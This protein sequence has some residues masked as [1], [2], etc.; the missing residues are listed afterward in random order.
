MS[1][2]IRLL[3]RQLE[4]EQ[5][6][7]ET[8][9]AAAA[10]QDIRLPL[11][12]RNGVCQLCSAQLLTGRVNA[13]GTVG[14]IDSDQHNSAEIMLCRAEALTDCEFEIANV[15]GPGEL[16]LNNVICQVERVESILAHVYRVELRLPAGKKPEFYAGQYLALHLPDKEA[17]SF[18]SIASAPGGECLE[19]H[20]Q[21]DP[22][23]ATASEIITYLQSSPSVKV[24]LPHGRACLAKA[25]EQNV[26]LLAAG[27]GFAQMKSI[28]EYLLCADYEGDI[29]LYW[30]VRQ[31][32]DMYL[33]EYTERWAANNPRFHFTSVI[34]DIE[35]I[36]GLEHHDQLAD[37]VLAGGHAL[38]ESLVF[39][40]G[41]PRLVF[42]AMDQFE[43]A[44]LPS[45]QFFSDVLE[46]VERPQP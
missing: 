39:V 13:G 15:Y 7:G 4:F 34:A 9:S 36:D 27:T 19:L 20:I 40:A 25:P 26:I 46:Y 44:G 24:S 33:K 23:L 2:R 10:R 43:A 28:I 30:G 6:E 42:S 12:C 3:P 41:S 31:E 18:F 21:A 45:Q 35:A 37:A 38:K 16:P 32:Q 29:H 17:P 22:H 8:I 5:A 11:S 14:L 1:L